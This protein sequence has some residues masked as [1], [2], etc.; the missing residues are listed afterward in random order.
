MS[1]KLFSPWNVW[2]VNWTHSWRCTWCLITLHQSI[3]RSRSLILGQQS[4]E[5]PYKPSSYILLPRGWALI[6]HGLLTVS[7]PSVR[8]RW[9][10]KGRKTDRV[11]RVIVKKIENKEEKWNPN[12][13]CSSIKWGIKAQKHKCATASLVFSTHVVCHL[14]RSVPCQPL[15]LPWLVNANTHLPRLADC[16]GK[17]DGRLISRRV[18][19]TLMQPRSSTAL[20]QLSY[21][22]KCLCGEQ[23]L[24]MPSD[25]WIC[26]IL[27]PP[28]L[29]AICMV[30]AALSE[31][32]QP[33]LH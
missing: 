15:T 8:K 18:W 31:H 27:S 11:N 33:C 1:C 29:A 23:G 6:N 20:S 28:V 30:S 25:A 13:G 5:K 4:K 22:G 24:T 9:W 32:F 2:K 14:T 19:I 7:S 10:E 16:Q 12:D 17:W 3:Q 26:V 21:W